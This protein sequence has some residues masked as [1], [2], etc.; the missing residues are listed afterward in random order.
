VMISQGRTYNESGF[1]MTWTRR[2]F[3]QETTGGWLA[4]VLAPSGYALIRRW[5][6]R[7][8]E[9]KTDVVDL[10]A[11]EDFKVGSSRT[12]L[13]GDEKVVVARLTDGRFHAVSGVCTHLGC[14]IRLEQ[15]GGRTEFARNC[16]D[17]RFALDGVNLSGPAP[18][19]LREFNVVMQGK[20]LRLLRSSRSNS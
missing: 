15:S 4:L 1:K 8:V 19:P 9:G 13:F 12:V 14:S 7:A 20:E 11:E 6:R 3:L 5:L 10:G 17:S 2:V 18:A 16:H